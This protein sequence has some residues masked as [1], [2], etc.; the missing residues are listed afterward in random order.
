MQI[1]KPSLKKAFT[2]L[3][4]IFVIVILGIVSS[5]GAEIIANVYES[6]IVQRAQHRASLKTEIAATQIANRL[7]YA[8]PGTVVRKSALA[9]PSPTDINEPGVP[10]DI[11]L[12]W[13]GADVDSFKAINSGAASGANRRP[14]WSGFCDV[15]AWTTGSTSISTPGSNLGLTAAIIDKLSKVGGTG[16]K[17]LADTTLF[18][19]IASGLL[20]ANVNSGSGKDIVLDA[21]PSSVV[22]HY[23]L[24]WTSYALVADGD[25][26]LHYNFLP[27]IGTNIVS[28][29]SQILLRNVSTFEF[30]GD[31]RTIRFKICV[32][33]DIGEDFNITI[34]KEK[35]VF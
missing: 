21:A 33:E 15:D 9:D 18:F 7:A 3:E 17:T 16:T 1:H 14:G 34:C 12:Q 6:Y 29:Q 8:I 25:L 24:A 31:G 5:I 11:I 4:L 26:T 22:E 30:R 13:V 19:P 20:A 27:T 28:S 2:L 23:K 35:A 10:A 32:D